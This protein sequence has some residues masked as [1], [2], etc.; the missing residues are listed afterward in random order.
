MASS[1]ASRA[2]SEARR[3]CAAAPHLAT[4]AASARFSPRSAVDSPFSA[5]APSA[6]FYESRTKARE[7]TLG[8]DGALVFLC[9]MPRTCRMA[10]SAAVVRGVAPSNADTRACSLGSRAA[11]T[12]EL[13]THTPRSR[14]CGVV[15]SA[16]P[17]RAAAASSRSRFR[18]SL[19]CRARPKY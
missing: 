15:G 9:W 11:P 13:G 7:H 4:T 5:A 1:E 10:V 12:T 19:T 16:L 2:L 14:M 18:R 17:R 3:F 8:Q 6:P